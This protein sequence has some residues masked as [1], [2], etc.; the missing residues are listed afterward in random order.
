MLKK[1]LLTAGILLLIGA[2]IIWYLYTDTFKDTAKIDAAYSVDAVTFIKE[3]E[4][5]LPEAN[6][7]YTE[8]IIAITGKISE[9]QS[10]D[11][12]IN[13]IITDTTKGSY[14]NFSFQQ[15]GMA[16][17]KLIKEGDNVYIK[18]SC[19]GGAYSE[20]LETHYINFKRCTIN[21]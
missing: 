11:S 6:K 8:K 15:Q 20:I 12:S 17:A 4:K 21:K 19:S 2:G 13:L 1:I 16:A 7:K 9:K 10:N 18:G 14:I 3:F 5:N